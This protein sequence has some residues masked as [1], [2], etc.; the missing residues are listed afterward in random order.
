MKSLTTRIVVRASLSVVIV[1]SP[2]PPSGYPLARTE[3][4]SPP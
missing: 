1:N 2:Y 4:H 3:E